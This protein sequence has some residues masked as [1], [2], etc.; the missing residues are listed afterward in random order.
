MPV[1]YVCCVITCDYMINTILLFKQ[2]VKIERFYQLYFPYLSGTI[3]GL[4]D[5]VN[6]IVPFIK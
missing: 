1:Q 2:H 5:K 6:A 4:T 3:L